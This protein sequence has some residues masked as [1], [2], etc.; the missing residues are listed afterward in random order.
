MLTSQEIQQY[1]EEGYIHCKG[2]LLDE[3]N[4]LINELTIII[5]DQLKKNHIPTD[6]HEDFTTLIKKIM[7]PKTKERQFIYDIA[8]RIDTIRKIQ[9]SEKIRD[10]VKALGFEVPFVTNLATVR[11]DFSG[12]DE[13]KY[14]KG[15][16]QDLR[17]IRSKKCCTVW[18][19]LTP[20]NTENGSIIFYPRTHKQGIIKHELVLN[21][22]I[23]R[24]QLPNN[25]VLLNVAPGDVLIFD[26]FS[27]HES[28]AGTLNDYIKVAAFF[29][30]NDALAIH[31]D[32]EYDLLRNDL[33]Y[34]HD[35]L[36]GKSE[37]AKQPSYY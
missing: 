4:A 19:P 29:G 36:K 24:D 16:H 23:P 37:E 26:S 15:P 12:E 31:I 34:F 5:K 13:T 3:I 7:R 32:D 33:P 22:E 6:E 30:V 17:L 2:I 1:N 14:L 25:K 35:I 27:I 21:L 18:F 28:K 10:R 20:C 8:P 11:M 9:V